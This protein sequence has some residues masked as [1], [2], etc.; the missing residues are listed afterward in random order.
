MIVGFLNA[1]V[2]AAAAAGVFLR[3]LVGYYAVYALL[4][5]AL[6]AI[7]TRQ[8]IRGADRAR[9]AAPLAERAV[10]GLPA[11]IWRL[12]GALLILTFLTPYAA[13]FVHYRLLSDHGARTAGWMQA[14]IGI[15]LSVRAVLG[16]AHGVFLTP[17]VNRGGSPADRMQWAN[18]FQMIFCLLAGLAVPPLLLFPGLAVRLL[19]SPAF[20]PGA[21]FV[22]V[23]VLM[24]IMT[25]LSGTH[26]ALV[27]ALD[28]MKF[29]VATN[30]VAQLLVV[31]AASRLVGPLGILGA[32]L[33]ALVAPVF[34]FI[35]TMTFLHASYDLQGAPSRGGQIGLAD[36]RAGYLGARGR[37][38]SRS[39]CQGG[40]TQGRGLCGDRRWVRAASHRC[41]T[42]AD[43]DDA[44]GVGIP[45]ALMLRTPAD[46]AVR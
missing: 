35:V 21:T 1:V 44:A 39:D 45:R 6:V 26:Q 8:A 3:G 18:N 30:L 33:A 12:S 19:Y 37:A 40:A 2:L 25:L 43:A 15:G 31:I 46:A 4:G 32:G 34:L 10:L 24:E 11:K 29:H 28:R 16:T 22:M 42:V 27:V 7:V 17:N 9:A 38:T 23:F 20:T 14:A 5:L 41:G 13:L 36:C